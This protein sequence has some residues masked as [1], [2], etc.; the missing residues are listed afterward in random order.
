M[1]AFW[2]MILMFG[3]F[4][5]NIPVA[6]SLI[7][8][9]IFYFVFLCHDLPMDMLIQ[10]MVAST[11]SYPMLAIPFFVTAGVIM[12]HSGLAE[13]LMDMAEV[14]IGHRVG[15]L[16]QVNV[17]N[18]AFM[19][20]V[21][22][23]A[24]ADCA[25]DSK[26]LVPQMVRKGYTKGFATGITA[27]SS[28]ITPIIP[29]GI[30]LILYASTTNQS[31]GDMFMAGYIPGIMLTVGLI[32][33]VDVVS[34]KRKYPPSRDRRASLK[35]ILAQV[36]T[37]I[38]ALGMPFG[39]ILGLRVGLFTPTECGAM[40]VAYSIFIGVFVYK[41]LKFDHVP[42]ILFE[43]VISTAIVMFIIA[44][45]ALFA[46]YLSWERVP[47]SIS[48]FLA[49]T[50]SDKI[51]FLIVVN[52]FLLF[53]GM[54]FDAS[55]AMIIFP[56]LLAPA[57]IHMG[58]DPIHFGIIMCVNITIGGVTPPYGIMMFTTLTIT[59]TTMAEY[60]KDGWPFIF[61]LIVTLG[62]ITFVPQCSTLL[63]GR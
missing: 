39:I 52:L 38:W 9:G 41:R 50:I 17:L 36:R 7:V 48:E 14:L 6:F 5:L 55:A 16:G 26:I 28:V 19:G 30:C 21:S 54:F 2:P 62:I 4:A 15:G 53:M 44:A 60:V 37:S 61:A 11:E 43:S 49:T 1:E 63:L 12:T 34:K 56:P 23:S 42:K 32:F 29:P 58:I 47:Q 24:T 57:A 27:A 10:S 18:S 33:A 35:E 59:K 46:R 22:G 25:F 40:A 51:T 3:L 8:S 31:I 20:G 45:A 13:G